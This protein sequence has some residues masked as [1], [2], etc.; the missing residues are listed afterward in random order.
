MPRLL[1]LICFLT[2]IQWSAAAS[3]P[4]TVKD[5]SLML[6]SGYSSDAVLRELTTRKFADTFDPTVEEDLVKAGASESLIETLRGG[7]YQLSAMDIAAFKRK[8]EEARSSKANDASFNPPPA[9]RPSR[10]PSPTTVQ[11]GGNMYDHLKDDLVCWHNGT[12]A[13]VDDEAL[14]KKK[15]FLLFFSAI[16][17]RDGRQFTPV[18][19]DYYNR[20]VPQHPELEVVF[21]SADRSAFAMENYVNQTNMPWPMVAYDKLQGKAGALAGSLTHQIPRL[22]LADVS[23]KILSDSGETRP[24]FDKVLTEADKVL[25]ANR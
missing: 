23:G 13:A 11:I 18:L 14:Q 19:A 20:V 9:D 4:L 3:Q 5:V 21:F 2:W 10:P 6:R 7:A 22:I 1:A 25:T 12:F 16:W 17:S 8:Q 15:F 24:E